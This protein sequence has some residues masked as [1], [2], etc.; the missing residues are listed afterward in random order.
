MR[1]A[2]VAT[3]VVSNLPPN[4]PKSV[5]RRADKRLVLIVFNPTAGRRRRRWLARALARLDTLGCAHRLVETT[6]RGH[7]ESLARAAGDAVVVA[8]GGDGTV[9]EVAAG[10]LGGLGTLG[11]LPLGTANV[12]AWE[13]G[14]P[15]RPRRRPRCSPAARP[16]SSTPAWPASR[17]DRS[18]SSCRCWAPAS[19]PRWSRGSTS[20]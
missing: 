18:A 11:V 7:A 19:T 20:A 14:L 15:M 1:N 13:L 3:A 17:M 6:H 12:L 16:G 8:A 10:L 4:G 5:M 2:Y 9:A